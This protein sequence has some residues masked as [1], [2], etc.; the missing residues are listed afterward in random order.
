MHSTQVLNYIK[1]FWWRCFN[2]WHMNHFK[3]CPVGTKSLSMPGKLFS[4]DILTPPSLWP[5][6]N[7]FTLWSSSFEDH[8][9]I[10]VFFFKWPEWCTAVVYQLQVWPKIVFLVT[11]SFIC[12]FFGTLL[13]S[14]LHILCPTAHSFEYKVTC[15]A[16][17]K[18]AYGFTNSLS[19][20][21]VSSSTFACVFFSLLSK[22]EKYGYSR[23][24]NIS[25]SKNK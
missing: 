3:Q 19:C 15:I 9:S 25:D 13:F 20:H 7:G 22:K 5:H 6:R 21:K 8:C 2:F 24:A 17:L 10:V 14:L 11:M 1:V 16:L 4:H 18:I 23:S 12:L